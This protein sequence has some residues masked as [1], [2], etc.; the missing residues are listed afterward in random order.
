MIEK[1]IKPVLLTNTIT[2]SVLIF[3]KL[4]FTLVKSALMIQ[5]EKIKSV[6]IYFVKIRF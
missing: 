1:F 4:T 3:T 6:I 5:T 2:L